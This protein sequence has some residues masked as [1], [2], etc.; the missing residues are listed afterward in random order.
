VLTL[1]RKVVAEIPQVPVEKI[2]QIVSRRMEQDEALFQSCSQGEA[3]ATGGHFTSEPTD[4][5]SGRQSAGVPSSAASSSADKHPPS[6]GVA[7]PGMDFGEVEDVTAELFNNASDG[8][9]PDDPR[10][11]VNVS[12]PACLIDEFK[13]RSQ[14]N[15]PNNK[16]TMAYFAGNE[17]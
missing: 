5:S 6:T 15:T 7:P 3:Y 1:V 17:T 12:I 9:L 10:P 13:R 16:E 11:L 14:G 4:G 2:R 8:P